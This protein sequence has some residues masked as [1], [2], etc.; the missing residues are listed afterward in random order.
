MA[1]GRRRPQGEPPAG[2]RQG[3]ADLPARAV[4]EEDQRVPRRHAARRGDSLHRLRGERSGQ[5]GEQGERAQRGG[6]RADS[7]GRRRT[8]PVRRPPRP[9][10]S[11]PARA[12][13]AR[14]ARAW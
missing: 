8:A 11:R 7:M 4:H 5:A 12:P 14:R 13:P 3:G 9:R 1:T 10:T 2:V 6:H